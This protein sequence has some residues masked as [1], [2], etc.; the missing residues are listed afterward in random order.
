MR[1][2]GRSVCCLP[3]TEPQNSS[4]PKPM[5]GILAALT[6]RFKHVVLDVAHPFPS[7]VC[8]HSPFPSMA[9]D[10]LHWL[11]RFHPGDIELIP[12]GEEE[13]EEEDVRIEVEGRIIAYG[14]FTAVRYLGRLARTYPTHPENASSVDASLELLQ[15]MLDTCVD[16]DEEDAERY[17]RTGIAAYLSCV[18]GYYCE[19]SV[20]QFSFSA[21]TVADICWHAVLKRLKKEHAI[22]TT[23]LPHL[24]RLLTFM[25]VEIEE[26]GTDST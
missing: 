1:I 21:P 8:L 4:A 22:D 17:D 23:G 25:E 2:S 3:K 6:S 20:W 16:E 19:E 14:L 11:S 12:C 9:W 26:E 24:H 18:E 15:S 7:H 10:I 13:E 5:S